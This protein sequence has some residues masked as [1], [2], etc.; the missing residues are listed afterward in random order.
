MF[1]ERFSPDGFAE[2]QSVFNSSWFIGFN[3]RGAAL[4]GSGWAR[5]P[6]TARCRQFLKTD[7]AYVD[8]SSSSSSWSDRRPGPTDA[9]FPAA[10][11]RPH[12]GGGGSESSSRQALRHAYRGQRIDYG[13]VFAK[14][15]TMT[16]PLAAAA[17]TTITTLTTSSS[18]STLSSPSLK[19][20]RRRKLRQRQPQQ[21]QQ[22]REQQQL[23]E[24][25][26]T[27]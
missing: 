26:V 4:H 13:R 20:S 27:S 7:F 14:L 19:L 3:R 1:H 24:Q 5:R 10:V 16:S 8:D 11:R 2:F 17:T 23:S 6:S 15:R 22:Q 9:L 12:N 21:Q 25:P 18:L